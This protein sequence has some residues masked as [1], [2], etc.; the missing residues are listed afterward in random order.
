MQLLLVRLQVVEIEIKI[1]ETHTLS[2]GRHLVPGLGPIDLRE[3]DHVDVRQPPDSTQ[4]PG[5]RL[6][7]D[8]EVVVTWRFL[9]VPWFQV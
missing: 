1:I 6:P 3:V 5:S 7:D 9:D 4:S 2:R 8:N